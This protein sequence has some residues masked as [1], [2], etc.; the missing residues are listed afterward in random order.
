MTIKTESALKGDFV[1]GF[2]SIT[3]DMV[4]DFVDSKFSIGGIMHCQDQTQVVTTSFETFGAFTTSSD[5][6]GVTE[7][8]DDGNY[9]IQAGADGAY[10][11]T[12]NITLIPPGAGTVTVQLS[13]NGGLLPFRAEKQL[14]NGVPV[15]FTILGGT[16]VV[17]TDTLGVAIKGSAGAT[18]D[19][20]DAQ[21][22]VIRA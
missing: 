9:T 17:E 16:S 15:T 6:K 19:I 8:L 18:L 7:D 20:T 1:T 5:T 10:A 21:F 11:M 13:K 3:P 2:R 14:A 12:C 4:S 22:R